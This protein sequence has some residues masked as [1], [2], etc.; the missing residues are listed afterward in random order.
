MSSKNRRLA[1]LE[2]MF[3]RG[4]IKDPAIMKAAARVHAIRERSKRVKGRL[5][6][7]ENAAVLVLVA[8]LERRGLEA[9]KV[10]PYLIMADVKMKIRIKKKMERSPERRR[11]PG[12][13]G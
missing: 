9:C 12:G 6:E 10:G 5:K 2:Q 13:K 4:S 1:T 7:H 3:Y 11:K 8:A